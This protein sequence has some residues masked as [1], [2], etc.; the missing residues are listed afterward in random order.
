MGL[1]VNGRIGEAF[2][3]AL[4]CCRSGPCNG[5]DFRRF[6]GKTAEEVASMRDA[7]SPDDLANYVKCEQY[8]TILNSFQ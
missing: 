4:L 3:V 2:G 5:L 7:M 8:V 1:R 6:D